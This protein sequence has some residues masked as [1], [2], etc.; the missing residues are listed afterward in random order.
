VHGR[1]KIQRMLLSAGTWSIFLEAE[2]H[3]IKMP[4][5]LTLDDLVN[6]ERET[7]EQVIFIDED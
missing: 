2:S 7:A 6:E 5:E 1:Q 3:G 4:A